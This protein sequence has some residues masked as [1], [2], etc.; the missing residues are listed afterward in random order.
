MNSPRIP[1]EIAR[2]YEVLS[3]LGAGGMGVVYLA[4][5]RTLRR[6]V[7][8]KVIRAPGQHELA[9]RL[10]REARIL[11]QLRHPA[12]VTVYELGESS[13]GPFL[14]MEWLEGV[15]LERLPTPYPGAVELMRE[16]AEGL[17]AVHDAGILHRDLKPGNILRS[18]DG[19]AHLLDFGLALDPELARL[20]TSGV[21]GTPAFMAPEILRAGKGY[22][23][24]GDWFSW[25][26]TLYYLL[27]GRTWLDPH[28]LLGLLRT[29]DEWPAPSFQEVPPGSPLA[30]LLT[31]CL[32]EDPGQRPRSAAAIRKVLGAEAP[33]AATTRRPRVPAEPPRGERPARTGRPRTRG[34]GQRAA[35]ATAL[36]V[37][38]AALLTW[39]R[40]PPPDPTPPPPPPRTA[41]LPEDFVAAVQAE[42]LSQAP[43]EGPVLDPLRVM[44]LLRRCRQRE[45]WRAW[46]AGAGR[47]EFLE[48][49][50]REALR[51]LDVGYRRMGLVGMLAP[52]LRV[53]PEPEVQALSLAMRVELGLTRG[54]RRE[55]WAGAALREFDQ[56]L[57]IQEDLRERFEADPGAVLPRV[58]VFASG[59][60]LDPFLAHM[61]EGPAV[62]LA[63][64]PLLTEAM[65][66]TR[67]ALYAAVRALEGEEDRELRVTDAILFEYVVDRLPLP[68]HS[69]LAV[70]PTHDVL[71]RPLDVPAG[72][73]LEASVARQQARHLEAMGGDATPLRARVRELLESVLEASTP[74]APPGPLRGRALDGLLALALADEAEGSPRTMWERHGREL[75]ASPTPLSTATLLV[76]LEEV[77]GD[78]PRLPLT[79]ALRR[80]LARAARERAGKEREAVDRERLRDLAA[81]VE[82]GI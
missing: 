73:L 63:L 14:V 80:A 66:H 47:P 74:S 13:L 42:L 22:S 43:E 33:P 44:P 53:R 10:R 12:V 15:T 3:V 59:L 56:A 35:L 46:L 82:A 40:S 7:A 67:G 81:A 48:A 34:R 64:Q 61:L 76:L 2:D 31:A 58:P 24:A 41:E 65:D 27:E 1:E 5:D 26:A 29:Q 60:R 18:E 20:T 16:V 75:E 72:W 55:G 52:Y 28:D 19:R 77:R 37:G 6:Q 36:G 62:R 8:L 30:K 51:T 38:I 49:D 68:F 32:A 54:P 78:P 17:Q 69:Q 45:T 70:L 25:G 23:A 39:P 79:P 50:H 21:V 4:R 57:R 11:P 9:G 71:G